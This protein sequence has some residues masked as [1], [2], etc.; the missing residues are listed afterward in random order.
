MHE[1]VRQIGR[2]HNQP[3]ALPEYRW[4]GRQCSTLNLAG[5]FRPVAP[6]RD[7]RNPVRWLLSRILASVCSRLFW[8][9]RNGV[10]HG[11]KCH[12]LDRR[13]RQ[14]FLDTANDKCLHTERLPA[15]SS[16]VSGP[17]S[18]RGRVRVPGMEVLPAPPTC[19]WR[20]LSWRLSEQTSE[21]PACVIWARAGLS[22]DA[23][24][25]L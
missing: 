4:Y 14:H 11:L 25:I 8:R 2:P 10:V 5:C 9:Q 18:A 15:I 19:D 6:Q 7:D 17:D 16:E 13:E 1:K 23:G 20:R 3:F 22:F 24:R 12:F 21:R